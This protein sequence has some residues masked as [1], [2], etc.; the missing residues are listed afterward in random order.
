MSRADFERFLTGLG[1]PPPFLPFAETIAERVGGATAAAMEADPAVWAASVGR[2]ARFVGASAAAFGARAAAADAERLAQAVEVAVQTEGAAL[3]VVAMIE[4][5][6]GLAAA[7]GGGASADLKAE[8]VARLETLC[9]R[10][11]DLVL[12]CEGQALAAA[13]IG[14]A[15][16][17]L[18]S[19]MRNIAAYYNVSLGVALSGYEENSF[20]AMEKLKLS[21]VVMGKSL[22]GAPPSVDLLAQAQERVGAVGAPIDFSQTAALCLERLA[23]L[24]EALSGS[25]YCVTSLGDIPKDLDLEALRAV[26]GRISNQE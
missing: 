2:T 15:H 23:R 16:L 13:D 8:C 26:S 4:G 21:C 11:P 17:K 22:S 18:Y 19:A 5:P 12:F 9:R 14:A 3:G 7:D 20:P 10:R 6:V 1:G 24:S 25:A